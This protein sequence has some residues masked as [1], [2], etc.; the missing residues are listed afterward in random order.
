MGAL[1]IEPHVNCDWAMLMHEADR[2][3]YAAKR[4]EKGS[5]RLA[6]RGEWLKLSA[7][8]SIIPVLFDNSGEPVVRS[9]PYGWNDRVAS[10]PASRK[11][12]AFG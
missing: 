6:V 11:A 10:A 3:M 7:V 9:D 5:L 2:L 12:R 8:A 1:V 4:S